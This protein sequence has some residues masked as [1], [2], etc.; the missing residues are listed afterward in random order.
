MTLSPENTFLASLSMVVVAMSAA[1]GKL[2]QTEFI[3]MQ[4]TI[5]EHIPHASLSDV[6]ELIQNVANLVLHED[7][8]LA[9]HLQEHRHHF[10]EAQIETLIR[11]AA[12][13]AVAD[14][15]VA[16]TETLELVQVG[17]ALGKNMDDISRILEG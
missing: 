13:V 1:D 16:A 10:T 15:D 8:D 7:F 12:K 2:E 3:Q 4:S 5:L 14:G 6:S 17:I 9:A 11:A